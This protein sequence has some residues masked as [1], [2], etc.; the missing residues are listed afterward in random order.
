M[1][2]R[3]PRSTLFPYTTLFRSL[4]S[5]RDRVSR[6]AS[7]MRRLRGRSARRVHPHLSAVDAHLLL[8]HRD[9]FLDFLDHEA[10]GVERLGA[11]RRPGGDAD[12]RLAPGD[13]AEA[14][15]AGDARV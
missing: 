15:T 6:M 14:V 9:P 12:A 5:G 11:M 13:P 3:P 4:A 10:A 2:R 1:I 7:D 8:P